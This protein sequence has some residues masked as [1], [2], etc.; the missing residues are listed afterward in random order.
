MAPSRSIRRDGKFRSTSTADLPERATSVFSKLYTFLLPSVVTNGRSAETVVPRICPVAAESRKGSSLSTGLD[1]VS[2]TWRDEGSYPMKLATTV[3]VPV[4][5]SSMV[6]RPVLSVVAPPTRVE[7]EGWRT[8]TFA[9]GS[10]PP[11]SAAS[12]VPF[13]IPGRSTPRAGGT[14]KTPARRNRTRSRGGVGTLSVS[15]D[16][17][18]EAD[19]VQRAPRWKWVARSTGK[20]RVEFVTGLAMEW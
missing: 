16:S 8:A 10:G 9:P 20:K 7:S 3:Y 4:G 6:K 5:R 13:T 1:A 17:S 2:V 11:D 18:S 19:G 12:T 14:T 15:G